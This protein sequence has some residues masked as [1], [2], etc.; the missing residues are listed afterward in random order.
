MTPFEMDNVFTQASTQVDVF[1]E[2]RDLIVSVI[3]GYNVCIFAYGQ[4]G[5]M[6]YRF[7]VLTFC[8]LDRVRHSRWMVLLISLASTA[9]PLPSSLWFELKSFFVYILLPKLK[10]TEIDFAISV[11][12]TFTT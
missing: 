10:I 5:R 12:R 1:N 2:A 8:R 9:A 6:V 7:I 4:V 11:F 3:D